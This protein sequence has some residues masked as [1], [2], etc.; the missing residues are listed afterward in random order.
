M[1]KQKGRSEK[2]QAD[3]AWAEGVLSRLRRWV[4]RNPHLYRLKPG[5]S[6]RELARRFAGRHEL[7][8]TTTKRWFSRQ[9]GKTSAPDAITLARIASKDIFSLDWLLND[10]G[11]MVLDPEPERRE[12]IAE[13]VPEYREFTNTE[14]QLFRAAW[15]RWRRY[16]VR[17]RLTKNEERADAKTLGRLLM[18][19]LKEYDPGKQLSKKRRSDFIVAQLHALMLAMPERG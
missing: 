14:K 11:P 5:Y 17:R 1:D 18:E 16:G 12:W 9:T 7:P 19:P 3:R 2:T 13:V 15:A 8:I 4:E 6:D 10:D